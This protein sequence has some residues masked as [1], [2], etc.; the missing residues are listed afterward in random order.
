MGKEDARANQ[1]QKRCNCL[2]H[3]KD[4][5]RPRPGQNDM[6]PRTVKRIPGPDRNSDL[7]D[8][9]IQQICKLQGEP[10]ADCR[11]R[12]DFLNSVNRRAAPATFDSPPGG[13]PHF[14]RDRVAIS[15]YLGAEVG[16][17]GAFSG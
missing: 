5:L 11:R 6:R 14:R 2:N 12:P 7:T 17:I 15:S 13:S 8:A 1:A 4:P 10:G 9:L 3:R 16:C